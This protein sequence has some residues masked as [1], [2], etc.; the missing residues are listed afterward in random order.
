MP[1]SPIDRENDIIFST[2]YRKH[3][4][5]SKINDLFLW[6]MI[7]TSRKRRATLLISRASAQIIHFD[8]SDALEAFHTQKS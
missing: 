5:I 4:A 3:R 6:Q 7:I 1:L 2:Y 8:M